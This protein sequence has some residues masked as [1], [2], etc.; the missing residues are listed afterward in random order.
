MIH[1]L[2]DLLERS[3]KPARLVVGLM[4]GT[5]ADSID[6]AVCRMAGQGGEVGVELLHYREHPHDLEVRRR[7]IGVAGLD[8]RGVAELHVL[9]GEAFAAACLATLEEA[10]LSPTDI[11]L[12]GSH[13][14]TVYHHSGVAGA[15]RATLQVGDGDVIAVRTGCYV[16][17]DFRARDVA[18]G[19]EGA[20]LSPIADAVLFGRGAGGE[21]GRRRA[22]LNLG[23][24]ANLTVLDD[25]PARVFGFD[26][27]PANA[28]LDRLARRL[29]G[30]AL[31]CDRDGRFARSGRVNEPL[32]AEL[33]EDDPF[34]ARRPPKSTGF[35][36]YGDAF[37][38]APPG[39]T[40]GSTPT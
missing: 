1:P 19:G 26:T 33:L 8:V 2:A 15:I 28:P 18:A 36:M 32:L 7:V 38:D 4:S 13:G 14:Q 22:I 35:E 34:L 21:P 10:G 3:N 40:A 17:S 29:S 12:I 24:I 20:P 9:V 25:D 6:V 5:S 37:V 16:I 30:G 27:G 11:D 31:G 23:G 39:V